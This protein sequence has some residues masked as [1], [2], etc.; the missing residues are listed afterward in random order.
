M[1]MVDSIDPSVQTLEDA[2]IVLSARKVVSS[3]AYWQE[4]AVK[5]R[6]CGGDNVRSVIRN[7]VRLVRP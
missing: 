7:F 5:D 2:L 3:P 1:H 6:I 4:H